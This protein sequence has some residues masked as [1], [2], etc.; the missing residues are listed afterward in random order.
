MYRRVL[1][2]VLL[3]SLSLVS[4][5]SKKQATK[6]PDLPKSEVSVSKKDSK[7]LIPSKPNDSKLP[8]DPIA[9]YVM[10]YKQYAM[11][12]MLQYKIP[13][14][15]TLAQGILES[16]SGKGRLAMEANNHFGIK[17]HDWRGER[18]Y[19]D[20]D[21]LQEC[22]RK[23]SHVKY[24]FRDHSLFLTQRGRYKDLF[25]LP[26]DDYKAWARGLRRAGYATDPNY[27]TKL[28]SLIERYDLH[29]FDQIVMNKSGVQPSVP[30]SSS[31]NYIIKRGDT[32]YSISRKFGVTIDQIKEA[33][34]LT[35]DTIGVGDVLRIP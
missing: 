24:S 33:N 22:F 15:I 3:V 20:D 25:N 21:A 13:A 7:P 14:S 29:N 1:F 11:D 35:S 19:H 26:I 2:V 23:Y 18:I 27:P 30:T 31:T 6:K 12:D 17:C 28:I 5:K 8:S 16:G 9:A 34:N 32:L 4:C 10:Q